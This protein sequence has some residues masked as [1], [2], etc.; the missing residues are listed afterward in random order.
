MG[1]FDLPE[2]IGRIIL[3]SGSPRR[4]E[5]LREAGFDPVVAPQ[6]VDETAKPGELPAELVERLARLK[7]ASALGHADVEPGDVVIA[8]DTIVAMGNELLGK[9]ANEEDAKR[10]LTELSGNKH[11]VDTGV[12]LVLVG[13]EAKVSSFVETSSV[14]FFELSPAEI[15]AYVA[16]GEPMDKAGSYGIQGKGRALVKGIEGCYFNIVG[17]PVARLLRELDRLLAEQAGEKG[18]YMSEK[19][20]NELTDEN[21][22]K[23]N[24]G[25]N[26]SSN[27]TI[28]NSNG[29]VIGYPDQGKLM[30]RPCPKC[31]KPM[32][33]GMVFWWWC[34]PCNESHYNAEEKEWYGSEESLN[35]ASL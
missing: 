28:V 7:A 14:E 34:D 12:C 16:T 1:T 10:M 27:P 6:D 24:G 22:E 19:M 5:L 26:G 33:K 35:R 32:H 2:R 9:P 8:A 11:H 23:V 31:G 30:Y 20:T 29:D 13:Q 21:M 25:F 15:E 3:A 18:A 4:I 17:L